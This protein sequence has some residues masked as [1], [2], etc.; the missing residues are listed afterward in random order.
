M[1][2]RDFTSARAK[3]ALLKDKDKSY[4]KVVEETC[5]DCSWRRFEEERCCGNCCWF[6]A[7]D[8]DGYGLC[9]LALMESKR[10]DEPCTNGEFVS[11]EEMRHHMAVLLQSVRFHNDPELRHVPAAKD[12]EDAYRFAYKYMKTFSKL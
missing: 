2:Q 10:C 1:K 11:K 6:Y 3:E 8:T 12:C 5:G 7:E 4:C 9:P